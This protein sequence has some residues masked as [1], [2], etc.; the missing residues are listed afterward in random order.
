MNAEE[1][2]KF[3]NDNAPQGDFQPYTY[4]S[5]EADALTIYFKGDPDYSKVLTDQIMLFLSVETNEI[6][7]CRIDGVSKI[8]GVLMTKHI[9]D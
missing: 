9:A 8:E 1:L 6:V 3:L 5:K 2:R 7:G 4:L